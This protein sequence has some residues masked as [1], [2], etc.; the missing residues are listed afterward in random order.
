MSANLIGQSWGLFVLAIGFG[1]FF[2]L[3]SHIVLRK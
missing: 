1:S 2:L 3:V